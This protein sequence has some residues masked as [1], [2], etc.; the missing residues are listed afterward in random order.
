MVQ[1]LSFLERVFMIDVNLLIPQKPPF[2]MV[3]EV[4][5]SPEYAAILNIE[6]SNIFC[7]NGKFLEAGLVEHMAQSVA[8]ISAY[9]GFEAM[10]DQA[11]KPKIGFIGAIKNL[12]ILHQ[13][14]LNDRLETTISIQ[15]EIMNA[16][17]VL[18]KT[19]IANDIIASAEF[20]IFTS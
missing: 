10:T 15:H 7:Q 20:K 5:N 4:I 6:S 19:M 14:K 1:L 3:S 11:E 17:I 12:Q 9:K 16:T 8:A 2:V 13:P 18:V